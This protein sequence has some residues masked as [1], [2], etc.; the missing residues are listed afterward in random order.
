[1]YFGIDPRLQCFTNKA[2]SAFKST[3]QL[4]FSFQVEHYNPQPAKIDL[5]KKSLP[6]QKTIQNVTIDAQGFRKTR[7]ENPSTWEIEVTS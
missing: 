3:I 2:H 4:S 5:N 7:N 1:M 6:K